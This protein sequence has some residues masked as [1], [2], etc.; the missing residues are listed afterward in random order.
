MLLILA[1]ILFVKVTQCMPTNSTAELNNVT[2]EFTEMAETTMSNNFPDTNNANPIKEEK[3]YPDG[4][5]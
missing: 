3:S 1:L 2:T 5:Q 4:K